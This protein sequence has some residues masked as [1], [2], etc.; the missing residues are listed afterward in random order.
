MQPQVEIDVDEQTGIWHIDGL[1]MLY[2]PRHFMVN[3]HDGV[4]AALGR[5]NYRRVLYDAGHKSA[6]HWCESQA[7]LYPIKGVEIVKHYLQRLSA[8][9]W[10]QF[11]L[12][13]LDLDPPRME[14]CLK[15]SIYVLAREGG[16]SHP[17]CYM[18]EGFFTGAMHYLAEA[19][20]FEAGGLI[21]REVECQ[22]MGFEYC[23]FEIEAK[24]AIEE[25]RS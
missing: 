13:R 1:P 23:R 19:H 20:G 3:V 10:G 4:E 14:I 9:G 16:A 15:N 25:E 2:I 21:C 17:V 8:R 24:T 11:S 7:A 5:E 22:A 18:F 6:H 12:E